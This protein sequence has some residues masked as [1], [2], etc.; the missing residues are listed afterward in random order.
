MNESPN[1]NDKTLGAKDKDAFEPTQK[2]L[3]GY[4][5]KSTVKHSSG[6]AF[7]NIKTVEN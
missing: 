5:N 1:N 6:A 3:E 4:K 2:Y 7:K